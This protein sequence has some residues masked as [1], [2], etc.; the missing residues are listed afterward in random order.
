MPDVIAPIDPTMRALLVGTYVEASERDEATSLLEE[1]EELVNTLGLIIGDRLLIHHREMHARLLIGS[2]KAEEIAKL[3][4][5]QG[6]DVIIFDHELTPSQQR[7]WETVSG[8]AVIDQPLGIVMGQRR[9]S[10]DEAFGVLREVSQ[11]GNLKLREVAA[12][13]IMVT[14]GGPPR[15]EPPLQQVPPTR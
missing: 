3:A 11:A 10:A 6:Y 12:R 4:E 1:L 15:P 9:C 8:R 5:T 7:N 14:S 13:L 2:G